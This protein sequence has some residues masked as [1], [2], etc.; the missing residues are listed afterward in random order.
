M[1]TYV[2]YEVISKWLWQLCKMG[3]TFPCF[4]H[5]LAFT[6]ESMA[7]YGLGWS[8]MV[9]GSP[10]QWDFRKGLDNTLR[11]RVWIVGG[12]VL[13]QELDMMILVGL[14]QLVIFCDSLKSANWIDLSSVYFL[15]SPWYILSG[16]K[17]QS[18]YLVKSQL[19]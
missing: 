10:G 4:C 8:S 2:S 13:N 12:P 16:A 11:C 9:T 19:Q 7:E 1:F 17:S 14:F 18:K 5:I 3:Q 15:L 6:V